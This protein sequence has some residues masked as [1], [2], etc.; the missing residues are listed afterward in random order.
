MKTEN[1]RSSRISNNVDD[2]DAKH[3]FSH[4]HTT[5]KTKSTVTMKVKQVRN[6][7][8]ERSDHSGSYRHLGK[9]EGGETIA[10]GHHHKIGCG[11]GIHRGGD[12]E[13]DGFDDA[14]FGT[15]ESKPS[16]ASTATSTD[17]MAD[18][19]RDDEEEFF[20]VT[21]GGDYRRDCSGEATVTGRDH[22]QLLKKQAPVVQTERGHAGL[23][24]P[25]SSSC[26]S[27]S[28]CSSGGG[29][30]EPHNDPNNTFDGRGHDK[31]GA[32]STLSV[33][34]LALTKAALDAMSGVSAG[35]EPPRKT[36]GEH[37]LELDARRD[38][39]KSDGKG[40][41]H[42]NKAS[43]SDSTG[44]D[45]STDSKVPSIAPGVLVSKMAAVFLNNGGHSEAR[46]ALL[47]GEAPAGPFV[48]RRRYVDP[49]ELPFLNGAGSFQDRQNKGPCP[50]ASAKP[51]LAP[52]PPTTAFG[53]GMRTFGKNHKKKTLIERRK[54]ELHEKFEGNRAVTFVKRKTWSQKTAH[55]VYQRRTVVDKVYQ[56]NVYK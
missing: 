1:P 41:N 42:N 5:K 4:D 39:G 52:P 32:F 20:A 37:L 49:R 54:E 38:Q 12:K 9:D 40:E 31:H 10:S 26:S 7:L 6:W 56:E 23:F 51:G 14:L 46:E 43:D 17:V 28:S 45:T 2:H 24:P 22:L 44:D 18:G 29:S 53:K 13:G 11:D 21:K 36:L 15:I 35:D 47:L 27:A 50:A 25:P 16:T 3:T 55:G 34:R 48:E 33:G 8:S 30:S 19:G